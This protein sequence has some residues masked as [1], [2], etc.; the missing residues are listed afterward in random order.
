M[1]DKKPMQLVLIEDDITTCRE[2]MECAKKRTDIAFA[3]IT[4]SSDTGL[5]YVRN[6]LPEAVILDLELNWGQGSGLDF[7]EHFTKTNLSVRPLVVVTTRNRSE[8]IQE[9]LHEYGVAWIFNK[10]QK[11]YCPDMVLNHLLTLR[12]YL[13]ALSENANP[14]LKTLES[15][16]ELKNR[17]T[18][19]VYAELNAVGVSTRY[20]GRDLVAEA[21]IRLLTMDAPS[22]SVFRDLAVIH[23]THYNN[24][25]RNIQ[26]AIQNAWN[27]TDI[28]T[29]EKYYTAPVR[30][31]SGAPT[32]TE[33]IYYYTDKIARMM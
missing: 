19:R 12:P 8:V 2:F 9:R 30:G 10:K 29:L 5:G 16:D 6:K 3:G 31:T 14:R 11:G 4:G 20:K 24:V 18:D 7:L 17:I 23:K 15:P 21:I 28:E 25:L 32:P 22:E 33:F 26:S 1:C 27:S 13:N